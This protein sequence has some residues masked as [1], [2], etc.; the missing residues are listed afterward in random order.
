MGSSKRDLRA[1]PEKARQRA[2]FELYQVQLGLEPSD[3][4]PMPSLGLGVREIRIHTG[5][6]RRVVYLTRLVD[7]VV[8]LH[9][10]EKK[11]GRTPKR[12]IEVA[13]RRLTTALRMAQRGAIRRT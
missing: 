1:F 10:F 4:K 5:L 6:E 9:A 11:T 2:G 12:D 7:S 3:W 8:V 13:R